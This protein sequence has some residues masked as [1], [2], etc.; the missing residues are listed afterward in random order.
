[1]KKNKLTKKQRQLRTRRKKW[2]KAERQENVV[3]NRKRAF[4]VAK[5]MEGLRGN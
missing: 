4:E 3:K 5:A 2:T 1:M